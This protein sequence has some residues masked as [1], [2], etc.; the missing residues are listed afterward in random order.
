MNLL[1]GEIQQR[2]HRP[3]LLVVEDTDKTEKERAENIFFKHAQTLA[4]FNASVIYTFPIE[5]RHSREFGDIKRYFH[6]HRMPNI[7][8]KKRDG[9]KNSDGWKVMV[10]ALARR[11]DWGLITHGARN[12][13]I[14]SSG[15]IMRYLIELVSEAAYR[16]LSR[17]CTCIEEQD[18]IRAIAELR[19]DFTAALRSDDY[20]LLAKRHADKWLNSDDQMQDLLRMR[21]LL[22][23]ENGDVWCDVRPVILPLVEEHAY[24]PA[25]QS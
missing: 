5:L 17:Q 16:A 18:T 8:L 7:V 22:E 14:E 25:A 12:S 20:P 23:Y 1:S 6:T 4:G 19:K 13:V 10:K 15:G 9:S 2:Y 24:A 11:M 3:V 21:A